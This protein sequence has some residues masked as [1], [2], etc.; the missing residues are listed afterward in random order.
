MLS[1]QQY[2]VQKE[3]QAVLLKSRAPAIGKP[4]DDDAQTAC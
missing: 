1:M 3:A 2:T 4:T